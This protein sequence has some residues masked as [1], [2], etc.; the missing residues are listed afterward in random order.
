MK[1]HTLNIFGYAIELRLQRAE[2]SKS[3]GRNV[4]V[5]LLDLSAHCEDVVMDGLYHLM[6]AAQN[7]L[8]K[9]RPLVLKIRAKL[10]LDLLS[11]VALLKEGLQRFANWMWLTLT[12]SI[13]ADG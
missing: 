6:Q 13:G 4:L 10:F 1:R 5:Y 12:A 3:Q 2:G 7:T 9:R 8:R 11:V